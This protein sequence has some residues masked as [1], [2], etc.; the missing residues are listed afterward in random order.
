MQSLAEFQRRS[1]FE[2][3]NYDNN[4]NEDRQLINLFL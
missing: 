3:L 2:H 1:D 4:L